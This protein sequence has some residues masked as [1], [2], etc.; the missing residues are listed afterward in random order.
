MPAS[1]ALLEMTSKTQGA[2]GIGDRSDFTIV[3]LATVAGDT[4][5]LPFV[6]HD[7]RGKAF[8]RPQFSILRCHFRIESTD[9]MAVAIALLEQKAK[10]CM[11]CVGTI[12][13]G[14]AIC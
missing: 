9:N 5:N 8:D 10:P 3:R 4:S 2:I 13:A 6:E 11:R 12:M 14:E 1:E 7:L